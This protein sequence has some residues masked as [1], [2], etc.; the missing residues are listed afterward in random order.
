MSAAMVFF[1]SQGAQ[2]ARQCFSIVPGRKWICYSRLEPPKNLMLS[3][4]SKAAFCARRR[5]SGSAPSIPP[6]ACRRPCSGFFAG[7]LK[8]RSFAASQTSL[9]AVPAKARKVHHV[10][11]LHIAAL[12]QVSQKPAENRGFQ[13]HLGLFIVIHI[14]PGGL[15]N[16]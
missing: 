7:N 1:S 3:R 6:A 4:L 12:A 10:N 2:C 8:A 16:G 15:H 14:N 9:K 13:F 5:P 11:V